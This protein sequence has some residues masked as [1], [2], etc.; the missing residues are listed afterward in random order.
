MI[1]TDKH[2]SSQRFVA[3]DSWRGICACLVAIYHAPIYSHI[4]F[5]PLIRNAWLFVDFFFVLSGFV[6]SH[7][8]AHKLETAREASDFL[9]RR[10]GRLWPLHAATASVLIGYELL[11]I[12]A[13]LLLGHAPTTVALAREPITGTLSIIA[14]ALLL[15]SMGVQQWFA[16]KFE[17]NYPSWSISVEFYTCV[18][19]ALISAAMGKRKNTVF[20]A[21]AILAAVNGM[22]DASM[23]APWAPFCRGVYAF[24][25]GHFV[26][27]IYVRA[28]FPKAG[29]TVLEAV[30]VTGVI[31]FV[32]ALT[33]GNRW[34]SSA[35]LIFGITVFIFGQEAGYISRALKI[36]FARKMGE[37]SY[38]I[39]LVHYIILW[40]LSVVL[41]HAH[42]T[43]TPIKLPEFAEP[44]PLD[45]FRSAFYG[46]AVLCTYM[47]LLIG[48][49]S[50]TYRYIEKPARRFFYK[51]AD[52]QTRTKDTAHVT[53]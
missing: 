46:D 31:V 23:N 22:F 39:Y 48:I 3:L 20:L 24:I 9:I 5:V 51:L 36:P 35:P 42:F 41:N 32:S 4:F 17:W 12:A 7:A 40:I 21:L 43:F 29:S 28:K 38:S 18:L 19:F 27:W 49:A 45:V 10:F 13:N 30:M 16:G 44:I 50:L 26:Y 11:R 34:L 6:L 8:Y 14:N 33:V 25:A 2:G 15:N 1:G 37:W 52:R 47:I 53:A